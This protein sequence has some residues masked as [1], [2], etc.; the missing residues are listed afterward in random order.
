M[1]LAYVG[2]SLHKAGDRVAGRRVMDKAR[3]LANELPEHGEKQRSLAEVTRALAETGD[4]E[5]AL[6]L[7][8]SLDK[9]GRPRRDRKDCRVLHIGRAWRSLAANQRDQDHDRCSVA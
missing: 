3:Q 2:M 1:A 9:Y 6:Q 8:A 7:V 4:F 5:G